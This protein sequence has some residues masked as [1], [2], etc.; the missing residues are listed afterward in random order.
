MISNHHCS[1]LCQTPWSVF[2]DGTIAALPDR[3]PPSLAGG[4]ALVSRGRRATAR[5]CPGFY[6]RTASGPSLPRPQATCGDR[7]LSL[8]PARV[9]PAGLAWP[10]YLSRGD[11]AASAPGLARLPVPPHCWSVGGINPKRASRRP[12]LMPARRPVKRGGPRAAKPPTPLCPHKWGDPRS[13][14]A[15]RWLAIASLRAT[16]SSRFTLCSEFFSSFPCG[17][18]LLSVSHRVFSLGW[19]IPPAFRLHSQA[20]RLCDCGPLPVHECFPSP[21]RSPSLRVYHPL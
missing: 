3:H 18:C 21:S 7:R 16:S 6:P 20:T 19:S 9:V 8:Q 15:L 13:A 2:Q 17:T 4:T 5:T 12:Q 10:S 11:R 14:A 1:L